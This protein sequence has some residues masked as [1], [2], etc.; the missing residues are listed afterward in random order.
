METIF[1]SGRCD[2]RPVDPGQASDWLPGSAI[3]ALV[4]GGNDSLSFG[5]AL[6]VS[7]GY[8]IL[9][10]VISLAVFLS[11][12]HDPRSGCSHPKST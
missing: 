6:A 4:A 5:T 11:A 8:A 3:A 1:A 2:V 7:A 12:T 10:L 9:G